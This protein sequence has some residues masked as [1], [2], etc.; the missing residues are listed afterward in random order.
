MR[1]PSRKWEDNIK[2]DPREIGREGV[3]WMHLAQ[4][5]DQLRAL[6]TKVMK[7]RVAERREIFESW[8]TIYFSLKDSASWLVGW[9]V[10]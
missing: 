6:T 2:M 10:S 8:V 9:L 5:R 7:L 4:D 1:N 3:D